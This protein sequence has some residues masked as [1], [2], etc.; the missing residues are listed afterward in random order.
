MRSKKDPKAKVTKKK[1]KVPIP[2]LPKLVKTEAEDPTHSLEKHTLNELILQ[3]LVRYKDEA[4]EDKKVKFKEIEH[5]SAMIE[6]YL[7]AYV[8]VGFTLQGEKVCLF[9]AQTSKDECAVMDHL[10]A[11]FFNIAGNRP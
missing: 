11:T 1:K 4:T 5:L 9:S 8:V 6:E 10:R 3:S 7:S 2:P